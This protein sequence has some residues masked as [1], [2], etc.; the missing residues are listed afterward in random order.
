[1][2]NLALLMF[3]VAFIHA[4]VLAER[5]CYSL[6]SRS[7]IAVE[8]EPVVHVDQVD[9]FATE[10]S[11]GHSGSPF[12]IIGYDKDRKV[13]FNRVFARDNEPTN[14]L[15]SICQQTGESTTIAV[16]ELSI[17]DRFYSLSAKK[18]HDEFLVV[19][20]DMS[21]PRIEI[22]NLL[23]CT[24][25]QAQATVTVAWPKADEDRQFYYHQELQ[26]LNLLRL[27][28]VAPEEREYLHLDAA[29]YQN[30]SNFSIRFVLSR[31]KGAGETI[32]EGRLVGDIAGDEIKNKSV[33][34]GSGEGDVV[35]DVE[36]LPNDETMGEAISESEKGPLER[37]GLKHRTARLN[38][39]YGAM[40]IRMDMRVIVDWVE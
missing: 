25:R 13:M 40:K 4:P 24:N 9:I 38:V 5:K 19:V 32:A 37:A 12:R 6:S 1:M 18:L 16:D 2:K 36:L 17:G 39:S 35:V 23:A 15:A 14:E 27:R 28:G 7:A 30:R 26:T 10:D 3:F 33:A 22:P 31:M 21:K 20:L 34:Y 8:N 11:R 29:L